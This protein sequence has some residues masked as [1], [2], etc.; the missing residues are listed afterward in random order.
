MNRRARGAWM[1]RCEPPHARG[2]E[3]DKLAAAHAR[4]PGKG[5]AG[6][7]TVRPGSRGAGGHR[8]LVQA[9][10]G[11]YPDSVQRPRRTRPMRVRRPALPGRGRARDGAGRMHGPYV[12]APGLRLRR[13]FLARVGG[14]QLAVSGP[15]GRSEWRLANG[16][17]VAPGLRLRRVR[18]PINPDNDSKRIR[19]GTP[20]ESGQTC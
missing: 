9:T 17:P 20:I 10:R 12:V 5:P 4:P 8:T 7:T 3:P 11:C 2:D 19:T 6:C 16:A 18:I 1:P 14:L 15:V 13:G